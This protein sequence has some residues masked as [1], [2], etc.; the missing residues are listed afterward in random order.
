MT[1]T[2]L[3][4]S[5]VAGTKYTRAHLINI[6]NN[7]DGTINVSYFEEEATVM[8]DGSIAK[9]PTGRPPIRNTVN[10]SDTVTFVVGPKAGQTFKMGDLQEMITSCYFAAH[11]TAVAQQKANEIAD[12]QL[13][14]NFAA[15]MAAA[16][17]PVT[18]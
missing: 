9:G 1:T 5:S 10:M 11:S 3:N 8:T 18:K 17:T 14:Q 13:R 16:T 4:Q 2:L 15:S 6:E 12:A 7:D